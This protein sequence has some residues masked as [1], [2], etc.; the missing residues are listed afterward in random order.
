MPRPSRFFEC[1]SL[2]ILQAELFVDDASIMLRRPNADPIV[3]KEFKK[4]INK[5]PGLAQTPIDDASAHF[6]R[7]PAAGPCS[8]YLAL[9]EQRHLTVLGDEKW[10]RT[11]AGAT[12]EEARLLAAQSSR[13]ESRTKCRA[14]FRPVR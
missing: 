11:R 6:V 4:A 8:D 13:W 3:Q 1:D 5:G 12:G 2:K 10:P 14:S 7:V 9:I